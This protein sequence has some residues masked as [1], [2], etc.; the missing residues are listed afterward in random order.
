M[1]RV[2][3]L[4]L[5]LLFG[6]SIVNRTALGHE[7]L[8]NLPHVSINLGVDL[9]KHV[10]PRQKNSWG[11][12]VQPKHRRILL[13]LFENGQPCSSSFP[14]EIIS[15]A[16]TVTETSSVSRRLPQQNCRSASE[17]H[18]R[19]VNRGPMEPVP[20]RQHA[21]NRTPGVCQRY[22]GCMVVLHSPDNLC[23]NFLS[24]GLLS[25]L[26]TGQKLVVVSIATSQQPPPSR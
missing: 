3:V 24:I 4:V 11:Y 2:T 1:S 19:N 6:A 16:H 17:N 23:Q 10:C 20:V 5:F 8:P 13:T 21:A 18:A 22:T 7:T 9:L 15:S 12:L 25:N 26:Q 14:Y